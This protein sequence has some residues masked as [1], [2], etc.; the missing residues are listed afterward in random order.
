VKSVVKMLKESVEGFAYS[1]AGFI[2]IVVVLVLVLGTLA[3]F[4]AQHLKSLIGN[5]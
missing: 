3:L 2:T 5:Q 1:S 4:I